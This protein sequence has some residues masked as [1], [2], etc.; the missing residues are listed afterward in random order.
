MHKCQGMGQLLALPGPQIYTY[1]LGDSAGTAKGRNASLFD[2]IETSLASLA[3]SVKGAAPVPLTAALDGIARSAAAAQKGFSTDGPGA[4]IQPL[5]DGLDQV[6]SLR[7]G[8]PHMDG[9]DDGAR[10][11]LD[12][13]LATK[14][15]QFQDAVVLA[16]AGWILVRSFRHGGGCGGAV[17][18]YT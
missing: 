8:L 12:T 9:L 4:T 17:A 11:E 16:A 6:R 2:G 7:A 14:E 13:R 5:V 18:G 10:Y 15:Q 3:R 1:R